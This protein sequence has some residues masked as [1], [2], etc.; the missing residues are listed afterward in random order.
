MGVI[1]GR[2]LSPDAE[3]GLSDFFHFC[4]FYWGL[5]L[6]EQPHRLMTD[7]FAA[8]ELEPNK[9]FTMTIVP[10][11]TYKCQ[12]R[13]EYEDMEGRVPV[14]VELMKAREGGRLVEPNGVAP[15]Y[16]VT[17]ASGR[18][19]D[20]TGNHPFRTWDG[21][22]SVDEGLAPGQWV[23]VLRRGVFGSE[24]QPE[25]ARLVGWMLADAH[26]PAQT[27]AAQDPAEQDELIALAER[28]GYSS[29]KMPDGTGVRIHGMQD[30][31][32]GWGLFRAKS[33]TKFTPNF[34]LQG[35]EATVR[36]YLEGL[37]RDAGLAAGRNGGV[38]YTSISRRLARDVQHL[39]VKFGLHALLT[40]LENLDG[41][42]AGVPEGYVWYT[43]TYTDHA[44]IFTEAA[45]NGPS[46]TDR[47]PSEWRK[48]IPEGMGL[49]LREAGIRVDNN[50]ATTRDKV[51]RAA[52]FL[53]DEWLV[54]LCDSDVGFEP[55]KSVRYL[56]E[57]ETVAA[58]SETH[59][60]GDGDILTHNSS[61]GARALPVW[62]QLRRIY[63][64]DNPYHRIML[65][66]ST[67]RLMEQHMGV[68]ERQLR[69][70]AKLNE[71]Y[72][73]LWANATRGGD[74]SKGEFGFNLFQRIQAGPLAAIS[75]PNFWIGSIRAASTG[76]H[77]DEAI[78]DDMND[79]ENSRTPLQREKVHEHW[80]LIFPL[81][82]TETGA[83]AK[84]TFIG[85]PWHDDDV[86]GRILRNEDALQAEDADYNSRW[87]VTVRGCYNDDGSSFFPEKLPLE[88]LEKLKND[89][90][91][92]LF[93]ANYECDP[94][95][96]T[97]FVDE[98]QIQW[99]SRAN[100]PALRDGRITVDP[101]Q[102]SD[103]KT[104][105]CYAAIMVTAYDK[106]AKMYVQD[107]RGAREW[108]TL[109]LINA[110]FEL[111]EIYPNYPIFIEDAHM[112]HFAQAV[113][114]E[115][116][117]RSD[118]QGKRVHLRINYMPVD[119]KASKYERA[120]RLRP[121]F[122]NR[123]V[124]FA[125]EISPKIK[126]EIKEELIRGP[127]VARFKDFLDALAMAENGVRPRL[128]GDGTFKEVGAIATRQTQEEKEWRP[129]W[130]SAF[131]GHKI[132]VEVA[133]K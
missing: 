15:V 87:T 26:L 49:K 10:R 84:I 91:P 18:S 128:N 8:N 113:S 2:R 59:T 82:G 81:I 22:K 97:G 33:A 53:G 36:A 74:G 109:D 30:V 69:F 89:M 114:L 13:D 80:N 7:C 92:R 62:K 21:W 46:P 108:D 129:T 50:Y 16:R 121:R 28:C 112:A 20:V 1:N 38:V 47:F 61:I 106:F 127:E 44:G 123:A 34:V 41:R 132:E 54:A 110:L 56:G 67:L 4:T 40:E 77:A 116:A 130:G 64:D 72:G 78:C 66:S 100:F 86:R 79:K 52:E 94:V 45:L 57:M 126:L 102:H 25:L 98:D 58:E 14:E 119:Y 51:R 125:D 71:A 12:S 124:F 122:R 55:I 70:N 99:K 27:V 11:G 75:E 35:D 118:E 85:T 90:G 73:P 23:A 88:R 131:P 3:K 48:R 37:F 31:W 29:A 60:L 120:D 19:L 6:R 115:E 32:R 111:Q 76:L 42:M 101:N 17:T 63:L 93:A 24:H 65:V 95:G 83:D 103:A 133:A 39:L 68:I 105:G 104:N 107:A 43:V 117:R 5:D 9:P 96:D